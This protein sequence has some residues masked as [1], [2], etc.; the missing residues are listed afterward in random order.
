MLLLRLERTILLNDW[1]CGQAE[2]HAQKIVW[3]QPAYRGDQ[4]Y[5]WL[6]RQLAA[7]PTEMTSLPAALRAHL[8]DDARNRL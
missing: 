6:Y 1:R 7:D 8:S 4:V 5:Q 2:L 3:G